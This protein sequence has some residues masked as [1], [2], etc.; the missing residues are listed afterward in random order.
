MTQ[1]TLPVAL[2]RQCVTLKGSSWSPAN[3]CI[4]LGSTHCTL[5]GS[6]K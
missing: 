2:P 4:G 1:H 3:L 6:I 5:G